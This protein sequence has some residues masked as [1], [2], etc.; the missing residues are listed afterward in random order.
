MYHKKSRSY[1][2]DL[3]VGSIFGEISFYT[4][5][6]RK[7]TARSRGFSELMHL[8]QNEFLTFLQNK[9]PNLYKSYEEVKINFSIQPKEYRILYIKCY[10]CHQSGHICL[11]CP[12]FVEIERNM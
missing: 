8:D 6:E 10:I 4:G 2:V 3:E 12:F 5:Q 7:L 1:I 9:H 11:D